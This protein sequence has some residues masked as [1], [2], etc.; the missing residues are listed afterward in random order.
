MSQD[1]TLFSDSLD[2]ETI[3]SLKELDK[4]DLIDLVETFLKHSKERMRVLKQAILDLNIGEVQ[5]ASHS[6]KGGGS[7]IGAIKFANICARLEAMA[8]A[9]SLNGA[10]NIFNE[11]EIEYDKA[12][13]A[14]RTELI[15]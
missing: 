9:G 14:L 1:A 3:L 2:A 7:T 4:P 12:S 8:K 15:G 6:M 10:E 11:L 13:H 5:M